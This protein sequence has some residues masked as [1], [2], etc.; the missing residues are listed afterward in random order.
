MNET[1]QNHCITKL[2]IVPTVK[3]HFPSQ[4]AHLFT[5]IHMQ[6]EGKQTY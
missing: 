5:L 4:M 1:Y 2:I 6:A 3:L